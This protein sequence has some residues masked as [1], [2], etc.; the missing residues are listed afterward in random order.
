MHTIPL[1]ILNIYNF[2]NYTLKLGEKINQIWKM[3]SGEKK[4]LIEQ[5]KKIAAFI[6]NLFYLLSW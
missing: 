5:V 6:L 2:I 1:F 4:M 3:L